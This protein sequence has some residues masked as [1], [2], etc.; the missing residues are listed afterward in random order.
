M[1]DLLYTTTALLDATRRLLPFNLLLAALNGW[2]A[3]SMLTL[4]VWALLTL[5]ALWL[6]WRIA[7]D[8][9]I[10]RRWMNENAD[11]ISAFDTALADLGLR[12]TRPQVP[13]AERCRGAARLCKRL[14]L[15]TLLQTVAT[16]ITACT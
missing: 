3:D 9:A 11:D 2:R 13:L 4:I 6:H 14:L 1:N 12:R 5:A 7:F 8:V 16:V 15:L 10:F